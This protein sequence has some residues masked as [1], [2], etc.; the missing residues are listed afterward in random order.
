MQPWP[1]A[2]KATAVPGPSSA[3]TS[4]GAFA[5]NAGS[6]SS[7]QTVPLRPPELSN[8]FTVDLPRGRLGSSD[9]RVVALP[10]AYFDLLAER[11]AQA[12]DDLAA[13]LTPLVVDDARAV[14]ADTEVPR[15]DDMGY[16][17][18]IAWALRG[19]GRVSFERW[20]DALLLVWHDPPGRSGAFRAMGAT[21]VAR[22]LSALT[23][24]EVHGAVVSPSSTQGEMFYVLL[25][26]ADAC[27]LARDLDRQGHTL[28]AI[29]D[30]LSPGASA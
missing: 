9:T 28:G 1:K 7:S 14:L 8:V 13:T 25:A 23:E 27:A 26:G 22:V 3:P 18:S 5:G 11:H 15:P 29:L 21:L 20:G 2:G 30:R 24:T 4:R 17:L 19:L 16:A 12:A 10:A 6:V